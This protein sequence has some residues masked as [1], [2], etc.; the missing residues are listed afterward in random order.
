[1][2]L[3]EAKKRGSRKEYTTR[4]LQD[5]HSSLNIIRVIK[6]RRM[7][8]VRHVA[9]MEERKS[10]YRIFVGKAERKRSL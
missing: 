5:V 7:R 10:A 6:S 1:M 4:N 3:R 8:W 9:H 2:G